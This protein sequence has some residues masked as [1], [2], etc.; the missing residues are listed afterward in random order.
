MTVIPGSLCEKCES[1]VDDKMYYYDS[2]MIPLESYCFVDECTIR[3]KES[4]VLLNIINNNGSWVIATNR[5]NFFTT[6]INGSMNNCSS[7]TGTN[8]SQPHTKTVQSIQ[9][10][11][12]FV[13]LFAAIAIFVMHLIF[14]ELRTVTGIIII[15]YS[16]SISIGLLIGIIHSVLHYSQVNMPPNVCATLIY[17]TLIVSNDVY[18]TAK[19][20]LL[21]HF[22]YVM[23]NSYRLS[24]SNKTEGSLLCKYITFIIVV[25]TVCSIIVILVDVIISRKAFETKGGHC[26]HFVDISD[27]KELV[28]SAILFF[29]F[30]LVRL[31]V[32]VTLVIIGFILY[33]LTTKQC[34]ATSTSRDFR[35]FIIL[36]VNTDLN[37]AIFVVLLFTQFSVDIAYLILTAIRV[38]EQVALFGLFASSSTVMCCSMKEEKHKNS[39]DI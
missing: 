32:Q 1:S 3:I 39:S 16:A 34:C 7:D 35:V 2:V 6:F 28:L 13:C 26:V 22:V 20:I 15:I 25:S 30:L 19:T 23:Y 14:K 27:R 11:L 24:G 29:I 8:S 4:T 10:T 5:T 18:Q 9:I 17:S 21:V 33:F 31:L 36:T 12:T 37:K 38:I